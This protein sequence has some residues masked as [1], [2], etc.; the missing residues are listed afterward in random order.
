MEVTT[1]VLEAAT[2]ATASAYWTGSQ[3]LPLPSQPLMVRG[4]LCPGTWR[5]LVGASWNATA[6]AVSSVQLQANRAL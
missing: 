2:V 3:L 6:S 4:S 1:G 5:R